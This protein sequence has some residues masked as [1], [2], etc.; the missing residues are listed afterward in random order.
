[1]GVE[2]I[3]PRRE[4]ECREPRKDCDHRERAYRQR[5]TQTNPTSPD[6]LV[7]CSKITNSAQGCA[8]RRALVLRS[9][10]PRSRLCV[11]AGHSVWWTYP[12]ALGVP[13]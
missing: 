11:Q 9:C 4:V 13:L 12:A 1:M 10:A 6:L 7:L 5:E 8:G 2:S 3:A